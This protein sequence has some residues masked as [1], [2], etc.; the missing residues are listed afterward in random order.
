MNIET[1]NFSL[2][3]PVV[4]IIFNRPFET[5]KNIDSLRKIKP[6]K[7]FVVSD[8]PRID[9]PKDKV[10]VAKCRE[11]IDNIDWECEIIRIYSDVNLGCMNRVVTGLDEVFTKADK[12]II[13]E[14]DCIPT[15][16]F[17]RFVEW[18]LDNFE[19]EKKVGMISGSNLI[20][21]KSQINFKNGFSSLINIW[22]WATWK[23]RWQ[24]HNPY[25]DITEVKQN[26]RLFTRNL[27]YKYWMRLYWQ[28]LFIY[29]IDRGSTWDF[30]LQYTFFKS[31]L[32]SVY[33]A[34]NLI[35][36]IGFNGDGTHT[37]IKTPNY[38]LQNI[39][40][41]NNSFFQLKIDF[42]QKPNLS[43]DIL[44]ASEIWHMNVFSTLKLFLRNKFGF[45]NT[46]KKNPLIIED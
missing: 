21:H 14:D 39:P 38:V 37:N 35:Y 16:D 31:N 3:T 12:A 29:T 18:G 32:I 13:L 43:R 23:D 6:K 9:I 46:H 30:Q 26:T 10:N 45:L 19:H 25:V 17:F 36:N 7:I 27:G 42:S 4:L 8:G 11:I 22:G 41:E 1:T 34:K 2:N 15:L 40:K 20:S 44:L 24:I 33:P 5:Q 28:E